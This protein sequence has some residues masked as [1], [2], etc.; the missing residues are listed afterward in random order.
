MS[1]STDEDVAFN[2]GTTLGPYE[3]TAKIGDGGMGVALKI[4]RWW[5]LD[6]SCWKAGCHAKDSNEDDT[7]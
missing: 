6:T 7:R 3:V 1:G 4:Y 2:P 5:G